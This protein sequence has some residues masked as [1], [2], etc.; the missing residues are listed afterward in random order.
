M[1]PFRIIIMTA[2]A[3]I[4]SFAAKAQTSTTVWVQAGQCTPVV[5]ST[6]NY[7]IDSFNVL[8]SPNNGT[9]S[10]TP[11][12][13]TYVYCPNNGFTGSDF[14]QIYICLNTGFIQTC[15]TFNITFVVDSGNPCTLTAYVVQDSAGICPGGNR[16]FI[17]ITGG[18]VPPFSYVWSDGST[19]STYCESGPGA[20]GCVTVT[21]NAGCFFS[22]CD[23]NNGCQ[24]FV[25]IGAYTMC[26]IPGPGITATATG[27]TPPYTYLW[28]NGSNSQ[29]LCNIST[30][31][32]TYYCLSVIDA[33]GCAGSACYVVQGPGNCSFFG[34]SQN[35]N[36]N[37]SS[38][39]DFY[40]YYDSSFTAS[41]IVWD[42]GDGST[43]TGANPSHTYTLC[44]AYT[45]TLSIT[46]TNGDSC[47]FNNSIYAACDSTNSF[48]GCQA[49]FY[50]YIDSSGGFQF[51]DYSAYNPVSWT[52]DFGDGTTST[53]QNPSHTYNA[54][55]S[56]N[57]CLTTV[58]A[59][60]C[61][62]SYCQ[63]VS[64]VPVQNLEAYLY[65]QTTVTPGFPV[66][67]YLTAFNSGTI[68]M[69]GTMQYHY[70]AGTTFNYSTPAPTT[71]DA[72]NH[73]LTYDF[74]SLLP[75]NSTDV[76]VDLTA[77]AGLQLGALANDTLWVNPTAG[78]LTPANN[79]AFVS[80]SVVGSWD[81]NDKAVSPKGESD[82]GIIPVNTQE[83]A[84]HIRFQNTGTAPA[85][86]VMI[87][88]EISSKLDLTTVQVT[89]ASH[90]HVTE[91]IGNE[92]VVTFANINLPDSGADYAAS[93]GYIDVRAKLKPG[94][95]FGTQIYNT[96]GIYFDFNAPVITNTVVNTLGGPTGI[97]AI[98]NLEFSLLPNPAHSELYIRGEFDKNA[99][100][101][102]IDALGHLIANGEIRGLNNRIDVSDLSSGIYLVKVKSGE[103]TGVQRLVIAK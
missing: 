91:I 93:Q 78:D 65:H 38:T 71:H 58:D 26:G 41:S 12:S 54:Q 57:V 79:I 96:A 9:I 47:S 95:S 16:S 17:A 24:I 103:K 87:R 53:L 49:Q 6:N 77:S 20:G 39:V 60:G 83:L 102:V 43:G 23:G 19:S 61:T 85:Q 80:D 84:Y 99:T 62:S 44:G 22:A 18:G 45:V 7:P 74:N 33:N 8:V 89:G 46:Y 52:W 56:W 14:A 28:S 2:I 101:D 90:Q 30:T 70:P 13:G 68:L 1:K 5:D 40:S 51:V 98:N 82:L 73:I 31:A 100:Y 63:Q 3:A 21:D 64:N 86:N 55:G 10:Y 42:F 92:L 94:L 32:G 76:Y 66:W 15:D 48:P 50:S 88:D 59:N 4:I 75:Y 97:N 36:G 27:G 37:G 67:V 11:A 35:P 25:S 81:P 69:N 34:Y 29:S 72:V